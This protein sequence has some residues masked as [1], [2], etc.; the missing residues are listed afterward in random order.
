MKNNDVIEVYH[1]NM[2]KAVNKG[3]DLYFIHPEEKD[4]VQ[5]VEEGLYIK[6]A[7]VKTN[8]LGVAF[9]LTNHIDSQWQKNKEVSA[10]T[11]KARSTSVGD[12]C[13]KNDQVF[14]VSPI[15]FEKMPDTLKNMLDLTI[16]KKEYK[17]I[18]IK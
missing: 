16:N 3:K 18:K 17:K 5:L 8:D 7:E 9:E 14:V 11:E 10:F 2:S 15:G 13:V 4:I 6:V 12:L 1:F